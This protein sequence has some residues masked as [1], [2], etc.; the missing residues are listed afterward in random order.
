LVVKGS[1]QGRICTLAHGTSLLLSVAFLLTLI[2]S[3]AG[4]L[5]ITPAVAMCPAVE[6]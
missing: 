1:F 2:E 5:N 6:A 4:K 3:T